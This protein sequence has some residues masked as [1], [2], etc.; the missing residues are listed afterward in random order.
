MSS[1]KKKIKKISDS[2]RNI[3]TLVYAIFQLKRK[4]AVLCFSPLLFYY[5]LANGNTSNKCSTRAINI[6][7]DLSIWKK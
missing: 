4:G 7:V 5:C 6:K 2:L 1:K 3:Y